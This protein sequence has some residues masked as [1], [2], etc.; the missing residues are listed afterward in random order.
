MQRY[1][2][3]D[4]GGEKAEDHLFYQEKEIKMEISSILFDLVICSSYFMFFPFT[5]AGYP[6]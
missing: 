1:G 3:V 4:K 5:G 6:V 2:I